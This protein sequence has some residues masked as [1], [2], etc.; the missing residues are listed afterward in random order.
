MVVCTGLH[1]RA[2]KYLVQKKKKSQNRGFSGKFIF[3]YIKKLLQSKTQ[4][5]RYLLWFEKRVASRLKKNTK[6]RFALPNYVV[7]AEFDAE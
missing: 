3:I 6:T 4:F 1:F 7:H 2:I 5:F